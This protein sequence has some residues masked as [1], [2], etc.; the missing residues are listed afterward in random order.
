MPF[1]I[2]ALLTAV[3]AVSGAMFMPGPWYETLVK[4]SWTPPN[5][6]FAPVWTTLYVMIAIAGG[7]AWRNDLSRG[8][9]VIW[10]VG[11]VLNAAWSYI[12]FGQHLIGVALAD[13]VL[14]WCAILAFIVTAWTYDRRASLLFV[15][16]LAWVSLATALNFTIWRMN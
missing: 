12:F 5:W 3:A 4:P 11:L 9:S 1:V 6:L 16:Y 7:L 8:T 10:G 13:I 14:L 15:P 2:C